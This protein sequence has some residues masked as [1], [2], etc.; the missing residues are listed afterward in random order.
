MYCI[1]EI[2]QNLCVNTVIIVCIDARY[3][4]LCEGEWHIKN[5]AGFFNLWKP[6]EV[7]T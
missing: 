2:Q 4:K 1:C 3:L 6:G 7:N 5:Y